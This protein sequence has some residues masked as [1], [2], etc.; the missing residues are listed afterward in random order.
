MIWISKWRIGG[1]ESRSRGLEYKREGWATAACRQRA[2]TWVRPYGKG[3]RANT[4][5]APTVAKQSFATNCHSQAGAWERGG[6]AGCASL[7][8]PSGCRQ[9]ANT[10]F[11]PTAQV[12]CKREGLRLPRRDGCATKAWWAVPTLRK[13][14]GGRRC[15]IL[16]LLAADGAWNAPYR[17][18]AR[19]APYTVLLTAES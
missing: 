17:F 11:A 9:R 10:R 12:F 3:A 18:G 7:S 13:N 4:R 16:D 1:R 14:R 6:K 19:C 8:R 15:Y 2:D 5:F